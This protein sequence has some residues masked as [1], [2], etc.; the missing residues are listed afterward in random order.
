MNALRNKVQL[1]GNLGVDPEIITLDSG[2]KLARF[3]MATNE[4]Y[5]NTKGEKIT[6]TTWHNIIAW[7]NVAEIVEKYME[8]GQE[9]ALQ[10][11]LTN[12]T[13]ETKEGQKRYVTEVVAQDILMLSK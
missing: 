12:R 1:M 5:K 9:I 11:K 3:S 13:Y 4:H 10:G 8:K 7:N 6:E 2:K